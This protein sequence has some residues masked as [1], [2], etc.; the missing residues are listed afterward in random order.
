V[1]VHHDDVLFSEVALHHIL[2]IEL[3]E[4][5]SQ[6]MKC[7]GL[8]QELNKLVLD[9]LQNRINTLI[10]LDVGACAHLR[11][12]LIVCSLTDRRL[13]LS[14]IVIHRLLRGNVLN[15]TAATFGHRNIYGSERCL[16]HEGWHL[17]DV[18][19]AVISAFP[20]LTVSNA[21]VGI[22]IE[23]ILQVLHSLGNTLIHCLEMIRGCPTDMLSVL[24]NAFKHLRI[25]LLLHLDLILCNRGHQPFILNEQVSIFSFHRGHIWLHPGLPLCDRSH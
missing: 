9:Q 21:S 1:L 23:R 2:D 6:L 20:C 10:L 22:L 8:P 3:L 5:A 17:I 24:V 15:L 11:L 16:L 12:T 25:L 18:V 13:A 14:H 7:V 4:S 19:C